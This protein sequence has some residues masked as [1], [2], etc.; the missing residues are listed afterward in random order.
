MTSTE[1]CRLEKKRHRKKQWIAELAAAAGLAAVALLLYLFPVYHL[2]QV[3]RDYYDA[4]ELAMLAYRGSPW[5]RA[6]AQ[7]VLQQADAAFCDVSHTAGENAQA[8]GLLTRYATESERGAASATHSLK[9]WSAHLGDTEG[10]LWVSYS[11]EALDS[12]GNTVQGGWNSPSL[13]TVQ[14]DASGAWTVTAIKEHP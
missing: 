14:K 13:W 5:D 8:Y 12:Q 2:L 3:P 7:A 9:L 10:Y 6:A 4:G 1:A 11:H